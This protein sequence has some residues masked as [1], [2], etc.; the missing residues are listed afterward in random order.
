MLSEEGAWSQSQGAHSSR[1]AKWR[2]EEGLNWLWGELGSSLASHC[3]PGPC[4]L[5]LGLGF[6]VY[7]MGKSWIRS[8]SG[9]PG[10]DPRNKVTGIWVPQAP[11]GIDN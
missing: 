3:E 2:R 8:F 11:P 10:T 7:K 1:Q 9:W 6:F 5:A 4:H